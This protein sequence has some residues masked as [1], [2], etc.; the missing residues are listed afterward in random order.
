M[1]RKLDVSPLVVSKLIEHVVPVEGLGRARPALTVPDVEVESVM[2]KRVYT[3]DAHTGRLTALSQVDEGEVRYEVAGSDLYT[4]ATELAAVYRLDAWTLYGELKRLY[5]AAG[6]GQGAIVP[7][8]HLP[9]LA[10]QIEEQ[11]RGY[12]LEEER[13]EV[14]LALVKPAGFEVEEDDDGNT[15]YTA[16]ITYHRDKEHLLLSWRQCTG[17]NEADFGFHYDPYNFDS[18]PEK[19]FLIKMLRQLNLDPDQVE[20]IYFT[21]ALTDPGKTD[22]YVEYLGTDGRWHNY[23]P[24]FVIRRLD[25]RCHIVEI[26]AERERSHPI[27]GENGR[28]AMAIRKW[29]DLNPDKL[30]YEMIF[31][32]TDSVAFNKLEEAK[33]F[34]REAGSDA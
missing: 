13:V 33:A 32:D 30:Q 18:D 27:D 31:T 7:A 28:K 6:N 23:S 11:T 3:P 21:G 5:A 22:F 10:A 14:A 20:D 4:A 12:T 2:V 26:K 34:I 9:A 15:I 16:E 24:D 29:E 19:D 8:S 25:G 17:Q 1:V